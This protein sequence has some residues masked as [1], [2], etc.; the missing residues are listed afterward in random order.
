M[1]RSIRAINPDGTVICETDTDS[2]G[3][4]TAVT[5]GTGLT[6]GGTTGSVT[7]NADTDYLQRRVS[8]TCAVGRSIRAINADGTVICEVDTD[9]TYTAS[10]GLDLSGDEFSLATSYRLPQTCKS[11]QLPQWNGT[12]WDCGNPFI[13]SYANI[14]IVA[15]SGGDFTSIQVAVDSITDAGPSTPYLV[16]VAPGAYVETVTLKPHVHLQG[17]GREVTLIQGLITDDGNPVDKAS[18]ILDTNTS[19]RDLTITNVGSGGLVRVGVFVPAGKDEVLISN[20]TVNSLGEA[21]GSYAVWMAG[22]ATLEN[23]T[24]T[25]S[26]GASMNAALM[27]KAQL[28][29]PPFPAEAT[30]HEGTY[31]A[32]DANAMG[33]KVED[34]D[35]RITVDGATISADEAVYSDGWS[36]IRYSVLEAPTHVVVNTNVDQPGRMVV[37]HSDFLGAGT[38]VNAVTCVAVTRDA[39]FG[40]TICP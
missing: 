33:I 6:G 19:V 37:K 26:G 30:L 28:A 23:V 34:A 12:T 27:V 13:K 9:T 40:A 15:K 16:W 38:V 39:A 8:A 10:T 7:L 2:G 11:G 25:A 36:E 14:V 3:D 1:G 32:S 29:S 18:L 31:T 21:N 4:I 24:A 20:V 22:R 35:S 5:A 17:A